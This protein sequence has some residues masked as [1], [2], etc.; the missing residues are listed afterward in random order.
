M[1][2]FIDFRGRKINL[3]GPPERIVSLNPSITET[4]FIIGM[5]KNVVGVSAFC[6]RPMEAEKIRKI[7]S[8]STYNE[9]VMEEIN[10]DLILTVSGYQDSLAEKLSE[11]YNLFQIELPSTP[12]GILDMINRIG[13]V[14]GKIDQARELISDLHGKIRVNHRKFR[15]YVEIDLGGHVTFGSQSYIISAMSMMGFQTVYVYEPK[16][17]IEPNF[18]KVKEFDPQVIIMEGK[19][20]RGITKEEAVK[21]LTEVGLQETSAMKNDMIFTTP[22]KLDFLAHHGPDFFNSAIPWLQNVYDYVLKQKTY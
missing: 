4:L 18:S 5:G 17:W 10:P 22:G 7:G 20:Y 15:T 12:F 21:K 1:T 9:N 6:R 11:K 19:M 2:Q 16:E 13:L 8:Y 3:D 14:T